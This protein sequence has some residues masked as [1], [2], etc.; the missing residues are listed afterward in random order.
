[1]SKE[2]FEVKNSDAVRAGDK[3]KVYGQYLTVLKTKHL[4]RHPYQ[5]YEFKLAE[6]VEP[7]RIPAGW[8]IKVWTPKGSATKDS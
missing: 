5:L 2:N 4:N 8:A 1:M 7:L 3:I 6:F